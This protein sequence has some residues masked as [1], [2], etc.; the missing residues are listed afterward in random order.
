MDTC[1]CSV[2]LAPTANRMTNTPSTMAWVMYVRP[3]ELID[4]SSSRLTL[5]TKLSSTY[6]G[7]WLVA[8][9]VEVLNYCS[10]RYS[11]AN[12]GEESWH[13][14]LQPLVLGNQAF[15]KH[16]HVDVLSYEVSQVVDT[17]TSEHEPELE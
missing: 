13:N 14:D 7:S 10:W 1:L 4:S 12:H 9:A 17:I 6:F 8:V 2:R 3:D 5:L 15:E 11:E 16:G